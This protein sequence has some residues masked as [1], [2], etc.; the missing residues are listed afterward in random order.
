M[1]EVSLR[2]WHR[3]AGIVIAIFIMLQAG[4]GLLMSM[5]GIVPRESHAHQEHD[6]NGGGESSWTEIVEFVHFGGGALGA[7]YR[8]VLGLGILWMAVSG[9]TIFLKIR[10]RTVKKA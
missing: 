9:T 4:S 1:K 3:N 8:L 6:G 7:L 2:R 5:E 10:A